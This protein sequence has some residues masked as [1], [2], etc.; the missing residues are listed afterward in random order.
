MEIVFAQNDYILECWEK[1]ELGTSIGLGGL[2]ST[3]LQGDGTEE[4]VT[5]CQYSGSYFTVLEVRNNELEVKWSSRIYEPDYDSETR[6]HKIRIYNL[7]NDNDQE[8]YVML[9]NGI[10]EC[11][12]GTTMSIISEWQLDCNSPM[13]FM[14]IDIDSDFEME[15]IICREDFYNNNYV[16]I[17]NLSD[18]TIE[19]ESSE[20]GSFEM[21]FG[22]V[23]NDGVK[24]IVL[25][26]GFVIDGVTRE[27]DWFYPGGFGSSIE[28]ADINGDQVSDII[29]TE[30]DSIYA[31]DAQSQMVLWSAYTED[32]G[33]ELLVTDI[34]KDGIKE[35]IVSNR[36]WH[37][38]LLCYDAITHELRWQVENPL[39]SSGVTAIT[40]GD[41]DNDMQ[42]EVIWGCGQLST[43]PDHLCICSASDG[44]PEF[45]E[46]DLDGYFKFDI[47]GNS[48]STGCQL[49][50]SSYRTNNNYDGGY[51]FIYDGISHELIRRI[52][53]IFLYSPISCIALENINVSLEEEII[54]GLSDGYGYNSILVL[55]GGTQEIIYNND[56]LGSIYY[57]EVEDVDNDGIKE[58]VFG[59]HS[60]KIYVMSSETFEIEWETGSSNRFTSGV[61]HLIIEN[62]D[63][64]PAKEIIFLVSMDNK[65][66]V[67][68][69]LTQQEQAV[70]AEIEG[71][72]T[73]DISDFN[74][75]SELEFCLGTEQGEMIVYNSDLSV[76]LSVLSLTNEIIGSLKVANIDATI[77]KEIVCGGSALQVFS[78]ANGALLWE[79]KLA[80]SREAFF[81]LNQEIYVCDIDNDNKKD[82]F[83]SN[84]HGLYQFERTGTE[85]NDVNE[86]FTNDDIIIFPNPAKNELII[87][88]AGNIQFPADVSIFDI[89]GKLMYNDTQG[90][91]RMLIIDASFLES[92]IYIL[93][94]S[95]KNK[96]EGKKFIKN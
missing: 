66:Y 25:R 14:I 63:S 71:L 42:K 59:N 12:D 10:I 57:L 8:I 48:G 65:V 85:Y 91:S 51:L 52:D 81:S 2:Y 40:T 87:E 58:I 34:E 75:D 39:A 44:I 74:N 80:I 27:V 46:P 49:A 84:E 86:S 93:Q 18:L 35:I 17:Y 11:Y 29:G 24:E 55:D 16:K 31:F 47:S 95:T 77:E 32:S 33:R 68:D 61:R 76:V 26:T 15:L 21:E 78:S 64:D 50:V 72:T 60:G 56:D 30:Y 1:I 90:L 62:I 43:G 28:V 53:S 73:I 5:W 3:D 67:Y 70:S 13:D 7:D 19:W 45:I 36:Y 82:I 4:L 23:D 6:I 69:G 37:Q 88:M 83:W 41:P 9:E 92:G 94:I 54:I 20:Y 96:S 89:T 79:S 22:D 38:G